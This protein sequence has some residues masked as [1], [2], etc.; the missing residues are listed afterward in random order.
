MP[1]ILATWE[2]E[3]GRITQAKMFERPHLNGKKLNMVVC[4][5]HTSSGRKYRI[6]GL[7]S[8]LT[9]AKTKTLSPK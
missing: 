9:W 8:R 3:I 7:R 1:L 2:A 4:A 5:C 6:G